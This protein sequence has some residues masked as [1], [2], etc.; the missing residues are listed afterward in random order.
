MIDEP[1]SM[2]QLILAEAVAPGNNGT[3]VLLHRLEVVDVCARVGPEE[4]LV[5]GMMMIKN[6]K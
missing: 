5:C 4:W 1:F 6:N 2:E 3:R